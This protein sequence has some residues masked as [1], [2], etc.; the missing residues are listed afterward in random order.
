[1]SKKMRLLGASVL[2]LLLSCVLQGCAARTGLQKSES[3]SFTD[4]WG[5]ILSTKGESLPQVSLTGQTGVIAYYVDNESFSYDYIPESCRAKT[6][7]EVR[8]IL[9]V[10]ETK[11]LVGVW[12]G[13]GRRVYEYHYKFYLIDPYT[14]SI[15]DNGSGQKGDYSP[16][17]DKLWLELEQMW[18]KYIYENDHN[19]QYM[20][21]IRNAWEIPTAK[22]VSEIIVTSAPEWHANAGWSIKD[23]STIQAACDA[24]KQME[25][26]TKPLFYVNYWEYSRSGKWDYNRPDSFVSDDGWINFQ[27]VV[28]EGDVYKFRYSFNFP[29]GLG[30]FAS[31]AQCEV[32]HTE[33]LQQVYES[34]PER[35][36]WW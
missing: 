6:P 27:F 12:T 18:K 28:A 16:N 15:I 4:K 2:I 11:K 3:I 14:G 24:L 20:S 5:E 35:P 1:M 33:Q 23:E 26:V 17:D 25:I 36:N 7:E 9:M 21:D 30:S 22:D 31:Y 19:A 10:E 13:T 32:L 8:G 34:A 29:L